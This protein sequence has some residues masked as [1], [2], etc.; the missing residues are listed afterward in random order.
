MF[1]DASGNFKNAKFVGDTDSNG[2]AFNYTSSLDVLKAK[3]IAWQ[4]FETK[5]LS[6]VST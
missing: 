5:L 3:R 6:Y 1:Y 4:L 2:L